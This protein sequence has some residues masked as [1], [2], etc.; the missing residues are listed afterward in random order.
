[1]M[2]KQVIME[3]IVSTTATPQ[4]KQNKYLSGACCVFL[5]DPSAFCFSW[6]PR[7][8]RAHQTMWV[9]LIFAHSHQ[10]TCSFLHLG[11]TKNVLWIVR[12]A[13]SHA[14]RALYE[15]RNSASGT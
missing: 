1:M 3:M 12:C 8:R 4:K 13:S 10:L 14:A 15:Y 9:A 6:R 5:L 2:H 11:I 7:A